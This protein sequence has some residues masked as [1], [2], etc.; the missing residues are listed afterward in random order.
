M[1]SRFV[2]GLDTLLDKTAFLSYVRLGYTLRSLTWE[3]ADLD[4]DMSG[5][6]CAVTGASSGLGRV[7]AEGLARMGARVSMLVRDPRKGEAVRAWIESRTGNTNVYL[8]I[9]DLSSQC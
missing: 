4:I 1:A 6:V 9:V 8:K 2:R 5:K 3:D 7:T